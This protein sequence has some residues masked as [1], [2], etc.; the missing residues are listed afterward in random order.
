MKKVLVIEDDKSWLATLTASLE[1]EN[2]KVISAMDGLEGFN[3]ASQGKMDLIL[4]DFMLP[5][6]NGL[7][8]CRRLRTRGISTPIIMLTG[9]RKEEVD[10]ILGLELG[11]DD[12]LIKPFGMKELIARINAVLR[13]SAPQIPEAVRPSPSTGT[14]PL[15]LRELTRGTTFAGRFEVVEEL[16]EGGMGKVYKVIDIRIKETVALKLL[17]PEIAADKKI[18]ERF[19]NE[20]KFARKISQRNVCRMF[21]L[22]EEQGAH[23]ITMEYVPGEDLKSMIKM[24][25]HLGIGKAVVI[26]KQVCEGLAE[27]H[28]LGVVHRDI[29]PQN[30]MID[31]E[32]SAR[33]MDFGIARSLKAEGITE[34]G[35]MVGTPEYM[36]PEQVEGKEIDPRS[37]IYS[38]GVTLYEMVTGRLPFKGES[39]LDTALKHKTE[40]PSDPKILNPQIPEDFSRIIL[41][42]LEK[43]KENRYQSAEE[44]V[45]ELEKSFP[46]TE[47]VLPK[48]E[49]EAE[50]VA[51]MKWK[52]S[53]A[54]LPFADIS[55]QKDQEYFCDG[56]TED[57]ITK[58]SRLEEL[59]VISRTSVMRYK[60]AYKDIKEIGKEL[61]VATIL[62]GSIRREKDNIRVNTQLVNVQDGFQLWADVFDRKLESVF[63]VQDEVSQAIADALKI[64]L[65]PKR[66]EALKVGRPRNI[67]AYEYVLKGM[68]FINSKYVIS[69]RE[70]DFKAAIKMFKKAYEL[71]PNYVFAY[72]GLCWAYQHH[73]QITGNRADLALVVRNAEK[74]YKINPNLVETNGA[75]AWVYFL[76]GEQDEAYLS[77]KRALE[78]NP[79][80]LGINHLISL[81]FRNLGLLWQSIEYS[82]RNIELDPFFL[83]AHSVRNRCLVYAGEFEKA[84]AA[85]RKSLEVEP[86]NFWS[87]QDCS[88][89]CIMMRKI[90]EA[91]GFLDRVEK[92]SPNYPGNKS[93][94]ALLFAA[95]GEKKKAL[96]FQK[97]GV[98]YS[99]LGMKDKALDYIDKEIAE[100]KEH[101][102]YSYFP[103]AHSPFY[104]SL[105]DE[106]RFKDIV[107]EQERKY[108]ERLKKYGKL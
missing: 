19:Q 28:K 73:Y 85:I 27:A 53:I 11:A 106:P 56:M 41:K 96:A 46:V 2:F 101:F 58:L 31:R 54:V 30:I 65:T 82:N 47:T 32:G 21:D 29:K 38:L 33:I 59:K 75:I 89:L 13:R 25:G 50:M 52:N 39:P 80:I 88:L 18:I 90:G 23:Y 86:D 10:K 104:D 84:S 92:I 40:K 81:F 57:I 98:I 77:Y 70:D 61:G 62:E 15:P 76:K 36:S 87:L 95:K 103:L 93:Y 72:T 14:L 51:E 107:K 60:K 102:Q 100:G 22:N 16:G 26:A 12:Y 1:A 105:R 34:V 20:L 4:L 94:K 69:H 97:N 5:S 42:C 8:I 63:E 44:V 9:E 83:P 6:L 78:I 79:N 74:A 71:D 91:E 67:D 66:V 64:K 24:T 48:K 45:F 108:E 49:P 55:L 43:N 35:A 17:R 68:H 3:L 37:D 99:L 7:E